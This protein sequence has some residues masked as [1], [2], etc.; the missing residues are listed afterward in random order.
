M[1]GGN[2]GWPLGNACTPA[3]AAKRSCCTTRRL[4]LFATPQPSPNRPHNRRRRS[5][6]V[7]RWRSE[8]RQQGLI[9]V[10]Q[11]AD[12]PYGSAEAE[13]QPLQFRLR[14]LAQFQHLLGRQTSQ[15]PLDG[16]VNYPRPFWHWASER[17]H[18][19]SSRALSYRQTPAGTTQ[20]ARGA[21]TAP[22]AGTV[23][24]RSPVSRPTAFGGTRCKGRV[25]PPRRGQ[26]SAKGG[27]SPAP[28]PLAG[29][30]DVGAPIAAKWA[31][32][33]AESGLARRPKGVA[34]AG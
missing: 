24:P 5:I 33:A 14:H 29:N 17:N 27:V 6:R 26:T 34:M 28:L 21:A 18:S 7:H 1:A 4:C 31:M 11:A 12:V 13:V 9:A 2:E 19:L 23:G 10:P 25:G 20:S 30:L 22:P 8:C 3:F 15:D 16:F 32:A